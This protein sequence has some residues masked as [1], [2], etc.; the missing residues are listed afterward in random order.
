MQVVVSRLSPGM[1]SGRGHFKPWAMLRMPTPT[2][3][4]RFVYP[5]LLVASED[6]AY[7]WDIPSATLSQIIHDTRM[8]GELK[9]INYVELSARYVFLCREDVLRIFSRENGCFVIDIPLTTTPTA[10][11]KYS[12]GNQEA[13]TNPTAVLQQSRLDP[14]EVGLQFPSRRNFDEVI[15]GLY[16]SLHPRDTNIFPA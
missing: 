14:H 5:T 13:I 12:L 16:A 7:I 10:D 9:E 6:E 15:A 4:Y 11:W 1:A 2:R 3:A 8:E